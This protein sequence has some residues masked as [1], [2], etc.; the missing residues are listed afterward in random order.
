MKRALAAALLLS[1][2]LGSVACD[3]GQP[4][5][6]VDPTPSFLISDANHGGG[7][8]RFYWLPPMVKAFAP[9]GVFDGEM[10]PVVEIC[11]LEKEEEEE[12]KCRCEEDGL[13][14]CSR[15][16]IVR[17][18]TTEGFGSETIRVDPAAEH[19]IVNWHTDQFDLSPDETYRIM[20]EVGALTLGIADVDPVSSAREMRNLQTGDLIPLS[21][22]RTL[23]IK[24][25]I[26]VGAH[27]CYS[28]T[29]IPVEECVALVALYKSTGGPGWN[30]QEGLWL[31][32]LEP[33]S[34][35]GVGC[36]P[37]SETP[38][39]VQAID[40]LGNN[41]D[42][43]LPQ[44]I[45]GLKNLEELSLVQNNLFG[46][47][48]PEVGELSALR[49]LRLGQNGFIGQ[50][51]ASLGNLTQLTSLRLPSNQ[52]EGSIPSE[53]GNLTQLTHLMLH[54]NQLAGELPPWLED[55]SALE[56]LFLQGNSFTGPVPEEL[57]NLGSVRSIRLYENQLSGPVPQVVSEWAISGPGRVTGFNCTFVPPGNEGLFVPNDPLYLAA[58]APA[59]D[60]CGVPVPQ[61]PGPSPSGLQTLGASWWHT[62]ALDGSDAIHC[63]GNNSYHRLGVPGP[64]GYEINYPEPQQL[65]FTSGFKSVTVGQN[66]SCGL[67][68]GG[69]AYC[70]GHN[71]YGQ[72]GI[73]TAELNTHYAEP[74]PVAGGHTFA[75]LS[76]GESH[77]CGV[78]E[79]TGL[80]YC[81]GLNLA[82]QLGRGGTAGGS[83]GDVQPVAGTVTFKKVYAGQN[84]T[85]ALT[86]DGKA[87]CWGSNAGFKLGLPTGFG[88]TEPQAATFA[89]TGADPLNIVFSSLA[90]GAEHTCGVASGAVY[91]WGSVLHG[92][93]G[94]DGYDWWVPTKVGIP[95]DPAISAVSAGF[96]HTCAVTETGDVFCWGLNEDG[97]VAAD[98]T[99]YWSTSS[100]LQVPGI[101]GVIEVSA[102][103]KHTCARTASG[104]AFCWGQQQEGRLGNGLFGNAVV[105]NPAAVVSWP[106]GS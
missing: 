74:K 41:L 38:Q 95:S 42:G 101:A 68:L 99:S 63:W 48:P 53:L 9:T 46:S 54:G 32:G 13:A 70:W 23:P 21:D 44:E 27:L 12:E 85:C 69:A 66:H 11:M 91:C 100:P 89:N 28:Q 79:G 29:Q 17:Y 92:K 97:Q 3:S 72:L 96:R 78:E 4:T 43:V 62:C 76:A 105:F 37:G 35:F 73:G 15:D 16:Y 102:G 52:L 88:Y 98:P 50:I 82:G 33:C 90:T 18:T 40:L 80:V 26:E 84:H 10:S 56:V 71:H 93:L 65:S 2:T 30:N 19:Y 104:G 45:R 49:D 5:Q 1:V 59:G 57:A 58:I 77:T 51:P 39:V 47:I 31:E 106:P 87:Y 61:P 67:T 36:A 14:G 7:N 25:R 24:F 20:V 55:L 75:S 103:W 83:F 22:G 60:V 86:D 34:W 64:A 6:P 8:Q 81:W 94:R